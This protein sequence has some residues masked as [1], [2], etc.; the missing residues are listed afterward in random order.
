MKY[1]SF[2]YISANYSSI[3]GNV[4]DVKKNREKYVTILDLVGI[5]KA[6]LQTKSKTTAIDEHGKEIT[7]KSGSYIFPESCCEFAVGLLEKYTTS[8]FRLLRKADYDKAALSEKQL[9]VD[10]FTFM[11]KE[12]GVPNEEVNMQRRQMD[13]RLQYGLELYLERISGLV[14]AVEKFFSRIKISSSYEDVIML[15]NYMAYRLSNTADTVREIWACYQDIR[16][17]EN[18][19]IALLKAASVDLELEHKRYV[20]ECELNKNEEY[21]HLW[22]SIFDL[23]SEDG[24]VKDKTSR[25][26]R[27]KS[28]LN[29]ISTEEQKRLF[30]EVLPEVD[31]VFDSALKHPL[32]VLREAVEYYEDY[33]QGIIKQK[34]AEAAKTEEE[35]QR[36]TELKKMMYEKAMELSAKNS[37]SYPPPPEIT[38]EQRVFIEGKN[39]GIDL[40]GSLLLSCCNQY[41][42]YFERGS[43]GRTILSCPQCHR[44]VVVDYTKKT[45]ESLD[46]IK[47]SKFINDIL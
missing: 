17:E 14:S 4:N 33:R 44:Y 9:L 46:T 30:G 39:I 11:L 45:S 27:L 29:C 20:L 2:E 25:F 37:Y 6:L 41:R 47:Y 26:N 22:K 18:S 10:W 32:V 7:L 38:T 1:Y 15:A 13:R 5:D 23:I 21:Q 43:K 42:L 34:E 3:S 8:D 24:Y 19:N 40:E 36:E 16:S 12:L 28:Q 31:L 35:R